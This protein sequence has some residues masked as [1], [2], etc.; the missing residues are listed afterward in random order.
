M[1]IERNKKISNVNRYWG[2]LRNGLFMF[3][4]LNRLAK[5]GIDIAPYYWVQEEIEPCTM[6]IIKDDALYTVRY[7]NEKELREVCPYEPGENLDKML[8]GVANGQLVIALEN[9]HK[10]AAYNL[11]ELND[12]DFKGRMFRLGPHEA[13]LSNMWTFHEYR[14]KNIAPHL[15]YQTYRLLHEKG[16][17]VKY[18]ITDYYNKSSIKF[19][20]KLNSKPLFLYLSIVLFKRYKWNFTLRRY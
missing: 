7:L 4:L 20:K 19:K 16:I 10:I 2:I 12:F 18:S 8:D 5:I 6:P 9:D 17:D 15:R 3:G 11:V 14:G 1:K 13:Y